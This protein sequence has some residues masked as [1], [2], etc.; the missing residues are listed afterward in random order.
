MSITEA[1]TL[2]HYRDMVGRYAT[3]RASLAD[4]EAARAEYA[5]AHEVRPA[6]HPADV[7]APLED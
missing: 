2:A 1:A 7:V 6:R 5:R 4:V 3:G